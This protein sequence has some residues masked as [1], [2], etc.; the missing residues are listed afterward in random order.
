MRQPLLEVRDLSIEI[1]TQDGAVRPVTG[2]DVRIGPGE[3]FG[4]V[5]ESGCGKSM[6][7]LAVL[8][9]LPRPNAR[10]VSGEIRFDGVNLADLD[11]TAL[12][13]V[14]GNRIGMIFQEPMTSLNP[15]IRVGDQIAETL[16]IHRALSRRAARQ[17]AIALLDRVGIADPQRRSRDYP[18]RLSGGMRQ[19]A[20]IAMAVACRPRLL[21]ADEPTTALD[22]T[23]QAQVLALIDELKRDT[24]AAV[25]LITH[26]FGIIAERASRVAVMYAGAIVEEAATSEI[27]AGPRHPYTQGLLAAAPRLG[28][29]RGKRPPRL[30]E[31]PGIVPDLATP[32]QGCAFAPRCSARIDTCDVAQPMLTE[33]APGHL[34]RCH[35]YGR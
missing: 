21:I 23:I 24:G 13:H 14:R 29:R 26:N 5:G 17:E 12:R 32:P 30:A 35:V 20:M 16:T 34:I 22:V 28:V 9:L 33:I 11:E 27:F 3:T 6:T 4:I 19:R 7:A 1:N 2:V 25:L 8:K 15:T 10:I 31:I 18:H